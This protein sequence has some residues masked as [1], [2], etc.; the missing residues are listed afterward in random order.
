MAWEE[1]TWCWIVDI[2][3]TALTYKEEG[4]YVYM[5]LTV[6]PSLLLPVVYSRDI[7][8]RIIHTSY[9]VV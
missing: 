2:F 8:S 3:F 5:L 1:S 4:P 7:N 6:A 9:C